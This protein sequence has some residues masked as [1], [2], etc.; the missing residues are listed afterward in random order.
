MKP[1][2]P[3]LKHALGLALTM[4]TEIIYVPARYGGFGIVDLEVEMLAAQSEFIIQDL[5]NDDSLGRIV[6]ILVEYYQ[7][8]SG[9][10]ESVLRAEALGKLTY[11]TPSLVLE[12]L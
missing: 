4:E 3:S 5:Q 10:N 9:L 2:L 11:L 7:M 8:E 1:A 6:K 12:L